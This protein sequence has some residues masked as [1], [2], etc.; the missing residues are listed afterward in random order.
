M[1]KEANNL[2]AKAEATINAPVHSVWEALITPEKI[3]KYMFGTT[4]ET[5]WKLG[6]LITWKGEWDGKA[7][8]DKGK[9]LDI[10]PNKRLQYSHYSPLTGEEDKPENYHT[11]TID[12]KEDTDQTKITLTQDGNKDEAAQKHSAENWG[13]MLEALKKQVEN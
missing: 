6:S 1:T 7:Y 11:V 3:Q 10:T 13:K 8:E 9:I 2:T 4:V 5:N 12:I